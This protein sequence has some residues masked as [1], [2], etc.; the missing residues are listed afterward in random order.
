MTSLW[1]L[2]VQARP[3]RGWKV[4]VVGAMAGLSALAFTVPF[5]REFYELQLP[6]A[7]ALGQFVLLGGAAA[8]A[9]E[10]VSRIVTAGRTSRVVEQAVPTPPW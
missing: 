4:A 6:P 3:L 5:A 8:L 2:V 1:V 7:P 9:I 10:M